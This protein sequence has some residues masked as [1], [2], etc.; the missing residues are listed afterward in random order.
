VNEALAPVNQDEQD[1]S[2]RRW[3][4]WKARIVIALVYVLWTV[5]IALQITATGFEWWHL[6]WPVVTLVMAFSTEGIAKMAA[7]Q[8]LKEWVKH[9]KTQGNNRSSIQTQSAIEKAKETPPQVPGYVAM[10]VVMSGDPAPQDGLILLHKGWL[11]I[12]IELLYRHMIILG[13]SGSGKTTAQKHLASQMLQI[14]DMPLYFMEGKGDRNL[15]FALVDMIATA[16]GKPVPLFSMGYDA[17]CTVYDLFR[18]TSLAIFNR[19][20][21]LVQLDLMNQSGDTAHYAA[22]HST[23]LRLAC[24][25]PNGPPK[26]LEELVDRLRM[27]PEK[28]GDKKC[29]WLI[30]AWKKD[31][32]NQD[33]AREI[34][35]NEL[36]GLIDKLKDYAVGYKDLIGNG[37]FALEEEVGA[38]VSIKVLTAGFDGPRT[39]RTI[40]LDF[41]DVLGNRLTKPCAFFVD[42]LGALKIHSMDLFLTQGRFFESIIIVSTQTIA[43]LGSYEQQQAVIQ[44]PG[45]YFQMY[46]DSPKE[47]LELGGFIKTVDPSYQYREGEQASVSV[48]QS[49]E[50]IVDPSEVQR[51][52]KGQGFLLYKNQQWKLQMPKPVDPPHNKANIATYMKIPYE[53]GKENKTDSMGIQ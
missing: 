17:P 50:Y 43:N 8:T 44:A 53:P 52:T 37:G 1:E 16:R 42:E 15:A 23:A 10:G 6:S 29:Q 26:S 28:K 34:E 19:M 22:T 5:V 45:S 4:A 30:N 32:F 27:S 48:R 13:K 35:A 40:F 3:T 11:L 46:T 7:G 14:P 24:L 41:G 20:A 47:I 49:S 12:S 2:Q 39:A 31:S 51:L 9:N 25:A 33:A 38:V 21:A 18:G 36:R